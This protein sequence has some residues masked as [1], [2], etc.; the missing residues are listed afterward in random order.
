[1]FELLGTCLNLFV[2]LSD[3]DAAKGPFRYLSQVATCH[4]T[5]MLPS[6]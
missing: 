5:R 4:Y 6:V 3:Q 1:L 2:N